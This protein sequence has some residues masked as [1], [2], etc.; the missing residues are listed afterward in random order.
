MTAGPVHIHLPTYRMTTV[1]VCCRV[2]VNASSP[3]SVRICIA[4]RTM[5]RA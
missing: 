5:R 1:D 4:W 2:M 3:S